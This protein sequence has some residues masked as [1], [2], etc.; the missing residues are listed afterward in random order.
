MS[1]RAKSLQRKLKKSAKF[2]SRTRAIP[3]LPALTEPQSE[4]IARMG[5]ERLQVRPSESTDLDRAR[6]LLLAE[7]H[8]DILGDL[9]YTCLTDLMDESGG[10]NDASRSASLTF[11]KQMRP[12][13]KD[14]LERLALAQAL[15]A[16]AR[17]AWLTKLATSQKDV[18]AIR[19]ACE[20][21]DRSSGTFARL[22]RAIAEYRQ[23]KTAGPTVS[24]GQASLAHNQ[25]V[26]NVQRLEAGHEKG[27]EQTEMAGSRGCVNAKALPA[28]D[29]RVRVT[30]SCNPAHGAVDKKHGTKESR[31]Q[32]S[33]V[34]ERVQ[35]RRAV[36]GR[37]RHAKTDE[38]ND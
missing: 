29:E 7:F 11:Q 38:K 33:S 34:D 35:T 15:L 4:Q 2:Q 1:N 26:Q 6:R 18:L 17:T 31:G 14:S 23:P 10:L 13:P 16:H 25:V 36:G 8:P 9:A 24:I 28:V 3:Q 12:L 22:M 5:S 21:A 37:R 30:E 19:I 27:D 32:G 20:A